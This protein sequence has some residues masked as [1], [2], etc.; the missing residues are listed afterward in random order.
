MKD[1][2]ILRMQ[3]V[4]QAW[5]GHTFEDY[6]PTEQFPTR[7]GLVGLLGGVLGLDRGDISQRERLSNSFRYAVRA[8]R[9]EHISSTMMTDFHTVLKSRMA[10]GNDKSN[11]NAVMS[12]REYLSDAYFTV[13]LWQTEQPSPSFYTLNQL[14]QALKKPC[15]TP[16]L[17][18]RSCPPSR[19]LFEAIREAEDIPSLFDQLSPFSGTI[20]SEEGDAGGPRM[21]IR[22][23]PIQSLHRQ[24]ATR[25]LWIIQQVAE[26]GVDAERG[27]Y[28]SQ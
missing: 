24:F 16:V 22:D 13:A 26:R 20:Y 14:Q 23:V 19:P 27:D 8:D 1:Y 3:G 4:M 2:L 15:Y 10:K 7:S 18:R 28:V 12:Y 11:K 9:R 17:G 6:R 21:R 25:D 5:G